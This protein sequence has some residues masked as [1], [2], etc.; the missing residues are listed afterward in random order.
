MSATSVARKTSMASRERSQRE[1]RIV[2]RV[3]LLEPRKRGYE[4][5]FPH[6]DPRHSERSALRCSGRSVLRCLRTD[7]GQA[8][9]KRLDCQGV[10]RALRRSDE[11]LASG[12]LNERIAD[13]QDSGL[14]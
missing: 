1:A 9:K 4:F 5:Q 12:C 3:R 14:V 8:G 10:V 7:L 11:E 6:Y 2:V 13:A